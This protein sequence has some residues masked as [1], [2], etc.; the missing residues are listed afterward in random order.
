M[1]LS[2]FKNLL[3]FIKIKNNKDLFNQHFIES[4]STSRSFLSLLPENVGKGQYRTTNEC[5]GTEG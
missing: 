2:Y 1:F 3:Y 4:L 5:V